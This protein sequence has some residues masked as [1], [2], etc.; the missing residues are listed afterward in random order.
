M[1]AVHVPDASPSI[2][3][4]LIKA[5]REG[6][7]VE[8]PDGKQAANVFVTFGEA[9]DL[10]CFAECG[11][12]FWIQDFTNPAK[13]GPLNCLAA[14]PKEDYALQGI[15]EGSHRIC[16]ALWRRRGD[17]ES[18][19]SSH[20]D[21]EVGGAY[22]AVHR[23]EV[24][25]SVRRFEDFKPAY[26]FQAVEQW[27]RLP[28]GLEI[29]LDLSSGLRTAKIPLPWKWDVRIERDDGTEEVKRVDI[30]APDMPMA[31]ILESLGLS[32]CQHDIVWKQADGSHEQ[33]LNLQWNVRQVSLWKYA[34]D[35]LIRRSKSGHL[36]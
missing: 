24:A 2:T 28:P 10:P 4:E 15:P 5:P 14:V 34:K 17:G 21:L 16:A 31:K 20:A 1:A 36:V 9:A 25:I 29:V 3:A 33:V 23:Q 19:P 30:V 22:E 26:D 6:S 7:C 27:H 11:L 35:I 12:A 18:K 32:T 8:L 13:R